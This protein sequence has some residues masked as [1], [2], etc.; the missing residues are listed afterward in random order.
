MLSCSNTWFSLPRYSIIRHHAPSAAAPPR[1]LPQPQRA[2]RVPCHYRAAAQLPPP[3]CSLGDLDRPADRA[4]GK[5]VRAPVRLGGCQ[6]VSGD[7]L[8]SGAGAEAPHVEALADDQ[9]V[10]QVAVLWRIHAHAL[11]KMSWL[12]LISIADDQA[13]VQVAV[14]RRV[15]ARAI[16]SWSGTERVSFSRCW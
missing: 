7:D 16:R 1:S 6:V 13:V 15:H 8:C 11:R 2:C 12:T 4:A 10:V 9:A 14:L 3:I 5:H